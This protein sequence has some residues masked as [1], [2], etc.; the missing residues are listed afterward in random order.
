M[1]A[2]A[3]GA[4]EGGRQGGRHPAELP[5][6]QQ[7]CNCGVWWSQALALKLRFQYLFL[8]S[9][10]I[11][12]AMLGGHG[13]GGVQCC[14]IERHPLHVGNVAGEVAQARAICLVWVPPVLKELLEQRGLA[15]LWKDGNLGRGEE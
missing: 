1:G 12:H 6:A 14:S 3:A 13:R 10:V 4:G 5:Q 15:T 9:A 2:G 7:H 8:A 11:V